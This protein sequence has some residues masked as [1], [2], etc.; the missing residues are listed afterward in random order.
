MISVS[1]L[2]DFE[3]YF[4][5]NQKFWMLLSE[6]LLSAIS[7]GNACCKTFDITDNYGKNFN[8]NMYSFIQMNIL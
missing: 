4:P 6:S 7:M 3:T 8:L 2:E 1:E 5:Q